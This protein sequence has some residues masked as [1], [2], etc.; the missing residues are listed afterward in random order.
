MALNTEPCYRNVAM[1][2]LAICW[3]IRPLAGSQSTCYSDT[4]KEN[5]VLPSEEGVRDANTSSQPIVTHCFFIFSFCLQNDNKM[6]MCQLA[7]KAV[8]VWHCG[9]SAGKS[10]HKMESILSLINRLKFHINRLKF[11]IVEVIN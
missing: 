10:L 6:M 3:N 2:N 7:T 9:Q 5:S 4:H 11:H 1:N 8:K